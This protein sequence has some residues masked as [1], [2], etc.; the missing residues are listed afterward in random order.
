MCVM[1]VE[2]TIQL[3]LVATVSLIPAKSRI[4]AEYAVVMEPRADKSSC[5]TRENLALPATKSPSPLTIRNSAVG[6][7]QPSPATTSKR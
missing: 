2:V 6:A 7:M 5:V 3:A 1:F 4:F